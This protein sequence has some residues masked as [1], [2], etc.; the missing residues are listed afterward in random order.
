M[1][2]RG[3]LFCPCCS[4]TP[5]SSTISAWLPP[6]PQTNVVSLL[7]CYL[8]PVPSLA[9]GG[10]RLTSWSH[11][12]VPV[13][14]PEPGAPTAELL[15]SPCQASPFSHWWLCLTVEF[16]EEH[17]L[18]H[19]RCSSCRGVEAQSDI[20]HKFKGLLHLHIPSQHTLPE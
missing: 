2:G 4:D 8:K 13:P 6:Q 9:H 3:G 18:K 11:R 7:T 16:K 14:C 10:F 19:I 12:G 20:L 15:P 5:A 1:Q 17:S